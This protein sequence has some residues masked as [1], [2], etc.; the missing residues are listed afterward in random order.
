GF[1]AADAAV[2]RQLIT[3]KD[4]YN[5][6]ALSLAAATAAIADQGHLAQTVVRIRAERES[7]SQALSDLQFSVT[8]SQA[9][10]VW[11][12][13]TDRPIKPIYEALK[14]SRILVRYM[15]YPDY[16]DGLRITVGD[17]EEMKSLSDRLDAILT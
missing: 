3:V 9:N 14:E 5:C 6:D 1:A 15:S 17:A 2:I 11:C 8:P 13:R 12:R 10:F 7:L 16:G 4:S